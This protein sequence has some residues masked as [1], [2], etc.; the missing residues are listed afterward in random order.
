[1]QTQA[2]DR[3]AKIDLRM[4]LLA[5]LIV[6]LSAFVSQALSFSDLAFSLFWPPAGIAFALIWRFGARILPWIT[7]G[8]AVPTFLLYPGSGSIFVVIGETCGPWAGVALLRALTEHRS[9]TESPLRWQISFYGCG[10]LLACPIAALLGS[11]GAVASHRFAPA[12]APGLFLAYAVVESIGLVLF[13]PPLMAWLAKPSESHGRPR[14]AFARPEWVF[15]V[16]VA[17]ETARWLLFANRNAD[18]ADLLIYCYFPLV[19]WCALTRSAQRTNTLL[20]VIAVA[21]LSGQAWKVHAFGVPGANFDLFRCALVILI[22]SGMGQLLAALASERRLAFAEIKR[23]LELDQLTGLLNERSFATAIGARQAPFKIVLL[24]FDNWPEHEILAGIGAS[25]DLQREVGDILREVLELESLAR[26]QPGTFACTMRDGID[27][28]EPLQSVLKRRWG[29]GGIEMRLLGVAMEVPA[30]GSL[31]EGELLLGARTVLNEA[32]FRAH[33]TPLLRQWSPALIAER[34]TYELLVD[35]IKHQVRAGRLHLFA[36]PI[37]PVHA[38]T[39]PSLEI[40]VRIPDDQGRTLPP[41]DVAQVLSQNVVSVELDR[42]VIKDTFAWF[43]ANPGELQAV[44]RVAINLTGASLSA[45]TLFEWIE[46]C[47]EQAGL[48]AQKF[49]FEIT[50][51]QAIR[52]MDAASDLVQGLRAAGYSVALDDFGTGLATFDYLKRFTVDYLKIDGS[53]IRN[54]AGNPIDQEIVSGIVRLARLMQVGTVAEYVS[55][56]AIGRAAVSAGVE[57]LQGYAISAPL[58][59]ADALR[60]CRTPEALAWGARLTLDVLE[61]DAEIAMIG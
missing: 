40:L 22:L 25:Y 19:A 17:I 50:E 24:A 12:S 18:Y 56:L 61:P 27:W 32:L 34:R 51:S 1:M 44:E 41:A 7:L 20:L 49:S 55:D 60:W 58:P 10:L 54:L 43:G 5:A 39:R 30:V 21:V 2:S 36:Q 11:L 3:A 42:A 53:F 45:P 6:M 37:A 59:L 38:T 29:N 23:Q 57:A 14:T 26:L 9:I 35:V 15:I 13:G 52:N 46:R 8:I 31:A 48:P 28:L 47:R 16:P 33:E 4:S